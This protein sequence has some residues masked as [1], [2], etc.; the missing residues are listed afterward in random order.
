MVA[1][2]LYT[3]VHGIYSSVCFVNDRWCNAA[4]QKPMKIEYTKMDG[5][6]NDFV[7]ISA[8]DMAKQEAITRHIPLI[9]HR[10][11]GI[12]CDQVILIGGG[13]RD[14]DISQYIFNSDGSQAEACGNGMRCV[15]DLVMH[16]RGMDSLRIAT[17]AGV[18]EAWRENDMVAVTMGVPR[19]DWQDIPLAQAG[20]TSQLQLGEGLPSGMAINL[21]N[22]HVVF[23]V[24]NAETVD[25]AGLGSA[26]ETHP[27][28]PQR[29]NVEFITPIAKNKIRMRVWERGVGITKSCGSGAV[30]SAVAAHRL[31]LADR[32][33]IVVTDGG[34]LHI[35]WR[36][37]GQT[38]LI[39]P[40]SHGGSG[41]ISLPADNGKNAQDTPRFV[42]APTMQAV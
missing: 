6:G 40:T 41:V 23:V 17:P 30:A 13:G 39:G 26:I 9:A 32:R 42:P 10:Q 36:E 8:P 31:G 19:F 35:H 11:R 21:G 28:F 24:E 29:T 38:V 20:D 34:E 4:R 27:L 1:Y 18:R 7:I 3:V 25:V 37:D 22:P 14:A 15:A 2:I 16:K 12:G 5:L 33:A